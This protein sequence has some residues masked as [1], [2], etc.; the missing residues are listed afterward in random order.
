MVSAAEGSAVRKPEG[1]FWW[2]GRTAR[3][4][5]RARAGGQ[6]IKAGFERAHFQKPLRSASIVCPAVLTGLL[7]RTGLKTGWAGRWILGGKVVS[8]DLL[9]LMTEGG[10]R[11]GRDSLV[12]CLASLC[13]V[14]SVCAL[15]SVR[16]RNGSA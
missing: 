15:V 11:S 6:A 10:S 8:W 3:Q 16:K 12:R 14:R 2:I 9:A 1:R 7:D 4:A 5:G 13:P